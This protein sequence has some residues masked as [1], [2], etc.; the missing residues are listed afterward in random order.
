MNFAS[1]TAPAAFNHA[2]Q[3]RPHPAQDRMAD[4]ALNPGEDLTGIAFEPVAVKGFGNQPKLDDEVAGQILGFG[5]AALFPPQA[6]QGGFV[7]A[8]NDAGVRAANEMSAMAAPRPALGAEAAYAGASPCPS[9][10]SLPAGRPGFVDV[11][12]LASGKGDAN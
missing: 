8:H 6:D 7:V 3:G 2:V 10:L 1:K 5:F 4:P 12:S 11:F 9:L